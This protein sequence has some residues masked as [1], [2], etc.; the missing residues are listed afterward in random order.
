MFYSMIQKW[1]VRLKASRN[2][3]ANASIRKVDKIGF[4]DNVFDILRLW[5]ILQVT[6]GHLSQHLKVELPTYIDIFFR[7]PGIVVLFAISGFLVTASCDRLNDEVN[8][9]KEY[10]KRRFCRIFPGLWVS[11][12][13]STICIFLCYGRKPTFFESIIYV[14]TQFTG[15]NFY[16]GEWL[17]NY[18]VG[19]P[20]GSLWTICVELQFYIF[21]FFVW[22]CLKKQKVFVWISLVAIGSMI[23]VILQK[24]GGYAGN[25]C[26]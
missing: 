18:G 22:K 1:V 24:W 9:K 21:I 25:Y 2:D 16:T 10:L 7:F 5:A 14:I 3:F 12:V 4:G 26:I 15:C 8:G 20:N 17:R 13:V 23:N 19:A 6:V 11:I